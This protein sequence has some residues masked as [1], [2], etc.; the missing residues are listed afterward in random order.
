MRVRV[1][2]LVFA[3][4]LAASVAAPAAQE[5]PDAATIRQTFLGSYR[6]VSYITYDQDGTERQSTYTTGQITY[7]AAGRMSAHLMAPDR[8]AN[9]RGASEAQ[10][11]AAASG[12]VAYFGRYEI[13]AARGV[14]THHVDGALSVSMVGQAMPRWY[15]FSADGGTLYLSTRN[16]DRVTGR[17]HWERYR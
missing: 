4:L 9:G 2:I 1:L 17:L 8:P 6:L 3:T 10:R 12:Y 5:R 15:E 11:A 16:G 7:D 14:V 13:D